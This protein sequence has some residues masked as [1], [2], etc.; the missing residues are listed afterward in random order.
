MS[1]VTTHD[2]FE[3][4]FLAHTPIDYSSVATFVAH[5]PTH[6]SYAVT[7]VSYVATD[8]SSVA[9]CGTNVATYACNI[10]IITYFI[11]RRVKKIWN[12]PFFGSF[13]SC[14]QPSHHPWG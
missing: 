8:E 5:V 9:T 3:A 10:V 13:C 2:S 7:F 1:H 4:T 11:K 14:H 12:M 6:D